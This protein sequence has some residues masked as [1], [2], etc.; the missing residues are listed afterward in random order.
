MIVVYL[1]KTKAAAL[2]PSADFGWVGI[3]R[4]IECTGCISSKGF[5]HNERR[6]GTK[7]HHLAVGH[8][9][10][11]HDTESNCQTDGGEQQDGAQRQAVPDVLEIGCNCKPAFDR[12]DGIFGGRGN[13]GIVIDCGYT[14]RDD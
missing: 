9:D 4:R 8:V 14:Q 10:D 1:T 7:H 13:F 11:A 6:V 2:D 12:F 3:D 5:L